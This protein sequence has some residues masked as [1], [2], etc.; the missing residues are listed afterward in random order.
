MSHSEAPARERYGVLAISVWFEADH[1]AG[2]RARVSSVAEDGQPAVLGVTTR[3]QQ[4]T[5]LV[6]EW[7]ESFH[8]N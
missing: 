8:E 2:F 6:R 5:D 1:V 4:V 7:L 3:P